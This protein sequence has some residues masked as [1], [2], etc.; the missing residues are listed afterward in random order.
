MADIECNALGTE[1]EQA[2]RSPYPSLRHELRTPLNAIIGYS[3]MLLE[4]AGDEGL[5][6]LIPDLE[7]IRTAGR[8]LLTLLN[9]T[10]KGDQPDLHTGTIGAEL[11]FEL[12]TPLNAILGY[13]E[14]LLEDAEDQGL[15]DWILD[16]KNIHTATTRFLAL[17]SNVVDSA[18][19]E[20]GEMVVDPGTAASSAVTCS[21]VAAAHLPVED[22]TDLVLAERGYLLVVD[23][24]EANRDILHHF[25]EQQG[26]TVAMAENG[27][28]ALEMIHTH[29][30][31][32]VLL[33]ILMPEM[34][35]YQ[36]LRRLKGDETW[37]DIPVIMIS[38]LDELDSIVRCIKM[39]AEDYL[40][41][42]FDP[43]LLN[44]RIGACLEKKRLR[45]QEVEYLRNVAR[46]T[47]AAASVEAGAFEPACL[48]DV[49]QRA[50]GLGQLA[51]VF[52]SMA[53]EVFAREQRLKQQVRDLCIELS[54]ARQARQVAEIT[55]TEYFRQLQADAQH[56]R[57]ILEGIDD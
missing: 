52:Q 47:A 26:Y 54:E 8:H 18:R 48:A 25:L 2:P 49:A 14:M 40:P 39:G 12:R 6:D 10:L 4:R 13:T 32:L 38:A 43:V 5:E 34:D 11:D 53:R 20:A 9:E 24:N 36:V 37:R 29:S 55:E 27:R 42:P 33:D 50:D 3:E 16:L 56:L 7:K 22:D 51:R 17:L 45:D 35:G 57:D 30:F 31:D 15:Q 41:K 28:Q 21:E 23:D 44:A 1:A 46:V 19:I